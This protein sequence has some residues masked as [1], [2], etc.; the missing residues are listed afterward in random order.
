MNL[1]PCTP[2]ELLAALRTH[3]STAPRLTWYGPDAERVEL[4]G[5]VLENWV[6]KTANY[7]VDELDAEPG[8]VVVVDMPL[9]WRSL[10]WLLAVWAV[11]ATA[12]VPEENSTED[13]TNPSSPA[14]PANPADIVAT[15]NPAAT[16][17]RYSGLSPRPLVV[18]VALPALQ[19]RWQGE[20][21]A[22]TLDYSGEVR[23]HA[24]VFFADDTPDPSAPAW[25]HGATTVRYD[26]LIGSENGTGQQSPLRQTPERIL[27]EVREGWVAVLS[28]ALKAW[29]AG[30]SVVLLDPTVEPTE[31]LRGSENIT[32]G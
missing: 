17:Q 25:R 29:A 15:T 1:Q 21:P 3:N 24:D 18:A 27:L 7:L 13:L 23:A 22:R 11:G 19:M 5:R 16:Q 31:K 10:V 32:Q 9:H 2:T 6:A 28:A 12:T 20:L 30:G 8:T 26:R 4:S 14:N